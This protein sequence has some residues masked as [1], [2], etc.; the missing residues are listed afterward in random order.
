MRV[1]VE[2]LSAALVR[3]TGRNS[4][5][6][7]HYTWCGRAHCP[8]IPLGTGVSPE[9]FARNN[10]GFEAIVA[11]PFLRGESI[12]TNLGDAYSLWLKKGTPGGARS[13]DLVAHFFRR[14]Y[15]LLR[16]GEMLASSPLTSRQ[17]ESTRDTGL[18][19]IL[20]E[21]GT[22]IGRRHGG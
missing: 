2:N 18:A 12:S 17:G 3:T 16:P 19:A 22:K 7:R 14:A 20:V 15:G 4:Q 5:R 10:P 8:A 13:A 9:V 21:G 1:R 6:N 11:P